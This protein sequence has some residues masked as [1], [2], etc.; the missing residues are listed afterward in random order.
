MIGLHQQTLYLQLRGAI[1]IKTP[2]RIFP[3]LTSCVLVVRIR[4]QRLEKLRNSGKKWQH[5]VA[6]KYPFLHPCMLDLILPRKIKKTYFAEY[7]AE[8]ELG[9]RVHKVKVAGASVT[10]SDRYCGQDM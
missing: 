10:F 6:T 8:P 3:L 9:K 7:L 5:K 1:T 4:D 2:A